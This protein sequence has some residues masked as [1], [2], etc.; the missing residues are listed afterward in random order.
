MQYIIKTEG[1]HCGHCDASVETELMKV[2]GVTDADADHETNT[3]QVETEGE[4]AAEALADAV[5]AAGFK[6]LSVEAASLQADRDKTRRL[7]KTARGQIDGIM[8]MV[9]QDRYCIDISTQ[10]MATESLLARVN[11]DVLKAHIEHCVRTAA[12]SGTPEEKEE[13]LEEIAHII[14]KL[15]R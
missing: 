7:L 3:V 10:L 1:L 9:E 13:K 6:A 4:V 8:R 15:N 2:A 14:D 11:A 5:V 12:E